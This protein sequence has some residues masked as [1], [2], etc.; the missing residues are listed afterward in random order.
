M[1][2]ISAAPELPSGLMLRKRSIKSINS[3]PKKRLS[4][5][6]VAVNPIWDITS[7]GAKFY[8]RSR[9]AVIRVYDAAATRPKLTTTRRL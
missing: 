8:S 5:A 9:R 2:R 1:Q 3:P 7:D 4:E 6:F